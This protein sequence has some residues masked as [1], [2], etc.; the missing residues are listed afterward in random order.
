MDNVYKPEFKYISEIYISKIVFENRLDSDDVTIFG[1]CDNPLNEELEQVDYWCDFNLLKEMLEYGGKKGKKL[2]NKLTDKLHE[3]GNNEPIIIDV[4]KKFGKPLYIRNLIFKIYKP[5]EQGDDGIWRESEED[6]L[7]II[8]SFSV[9]DGILDVDS[10]TEKLNVA[11]T[12]QLLV[13]SHAYSLY[14]QLLKQN[15]SKKKARKLA[16][17]T[18]DMLFKLAKLNYKLIKKNLSE[19]DPEDEE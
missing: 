16:R 1:Y 19:T 12:E 7:Y 6:E 4:E 13:L 2:L 15:L 9:D 11:M 18:D 17:L 8:D 10:E 14:L 5:K 3:E